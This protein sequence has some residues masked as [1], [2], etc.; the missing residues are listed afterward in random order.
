MG[1]QTPNM[2]MVCLSA[3][4]VRETEAREKDGPAAHSF[5]VCPQGLLSLLP[6]WLWPQR[7]LIHLTSRSRTSETLGTS[8][9]RLLSSSD[10]WVAG[11][12]T[13][14]AE[15]DPPAWVDLDT[16]GD[17]RDLTPS[18]LPPLVLYMGSAPCRTWLSVWPTRLVPGFI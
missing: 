4:P 1:S 17:Q 6:L 8:H 12:G 10:W 18:R 13:A 9:F 14:P 5:G 15:T 7:G 2:P 11:G 3:C 16:P